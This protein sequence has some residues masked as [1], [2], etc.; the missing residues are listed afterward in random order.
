MANWGDSKSF[1]KGEIDFFSLLLLGFGNLRVLYY[2]IASV[3]AEGL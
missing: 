3:S 1:W 2:F